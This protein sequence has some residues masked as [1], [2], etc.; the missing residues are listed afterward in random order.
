MV[1]LKQMENS[2]N[3]IIKKFEDTPK[4]VY[5][6]MVYIDKFGRHEHTVTFDK[7]IE[8]VFDNILLLN[9]CDCTS[10]SNFEINKKRFC[11]YKIAATKELVRRGFLKE[12]FYEEIKE[13]AHEDD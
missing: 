3:V 1:S 11:M 9:H 13:N 2:E 4:R 10:C 5:I 6:D 12:G 7:T 8:P